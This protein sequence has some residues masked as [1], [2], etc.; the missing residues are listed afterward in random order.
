MADSKLRAAPPLQTCGA[1][2]V[3]NGPNIQLICDAA[4][5]TTAGMWDTPARQCLSLFVCVAS[6]FSEVARSIVH[7]W[8]EKQTVFLCQ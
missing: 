1:W 3:E 8:K 2:E 5:V 6:K 7:N 4:A